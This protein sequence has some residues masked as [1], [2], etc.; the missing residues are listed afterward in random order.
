[1][2]LTRGKNFLDSEE[3]KDIRRVLEQ[4]T[5]DTSY[6]TVSSYSADSSTY[7]DNLMPFVDKHLNYLTGHP[8][9][10]ASSYLANIKLMTRIR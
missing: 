2:A 10:E 1:M 8:K 9:V 5:L 4:M 3:G 6:S 7:P